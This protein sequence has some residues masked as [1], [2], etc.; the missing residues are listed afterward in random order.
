MTVVVE[1]SD[2]L[3][4][5]ESFKELLCIILMLGNYMNG[6]SFQG[7][8]FGM[9]VSSINKLADTKASNTSSVSL[10]H[11][12][13]GITRRQFPHVQRFLHDLRNVNSATRIMASVNDMVEQYTEMRQHLKKLDTELET[14]WQNV[15]LDPNDRF[16]QV[17]TKHRNA[18]TERFEELKHFISTWMPNGRM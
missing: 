13:V 5:S 1:V 9:R 3:R 6:T 2:S 8:A 7:G 16:L 15:E 11:V 14:Q 18:A 4:H 17:M 10:L 12:L